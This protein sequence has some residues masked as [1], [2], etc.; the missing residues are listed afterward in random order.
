MISFLTGGPF[1]PSRKRSVEA[2]IKIAR[3]KPGMV[4]YDLGCGDGRVLVEAAKR[5][6]KPV[7]IEINPFLVIFC[8]LKKLHVR[9]QNL[10]NADISEAHIVF[11]Y[12]L[13][14]HMKKLE[15]KLKKELQPG[16]LVVSN[17]FIFPKWKIIRSDVKN[18]VYVFRVI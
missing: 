16:S 2:M 15:Q 8:R 10:W 13:P 4:V 7:G 3:L 18:H 11:V 14:N 5:G 6:A 9:W 1:V 17:S 12:L